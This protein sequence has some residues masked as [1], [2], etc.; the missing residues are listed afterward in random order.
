[1]FDYSGTTALNNKS[2]N[3]ISQG[4]FA[5][6]EDSRKRVKKYFENV[7]QNIIVVGQGSQIKNVI[8]RLHSDLSS[9]N[10]KNVVHVVVGSDPLNSVINGLNEY[11]QLYPTIECYNVNILLSISDTEEKER[12]LKQYEQVLKNFTSQL[13]DIKKQQFII[14]KN[15]SSLNETVVKILLTLKGSP[16][17]II[18]EAREIL[19]RE[20][21]D[22][23]KDFMKSLQEYKKT[24]D[25]SLEDA[26]QTKKDLSILT[27][28][29]SKLPRSIQ[30]SFNPVLQST[31]DDVNT[32]YNKQKEKI[33]NQQLK[34]LINVFKKTNKENAIIDLHTLSTLTMLDVPTIITLIPEFLKTQPEFGYL[35]NRL[36]YLNENI[37]LKAGQ[38]LNGLR[39]DMYKALEASN[40]ENAHVS[41]QQALEY[42]DFL[43]RGYNFIKKPDIAQR[44]IN[45]KQYLVQELQDIV[46]D[47]K[48]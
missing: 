11:V 21:K 17:I 24:A 35:D 37:L 25:K 12:L 3:S 38:F 7:L 43:V 33:I 41:L 31:I 19:I 8:Q 2:L 40:F 34:T 16:T 5:T 4:V 30:V 42:Y 47:V 36:V 15:L 29:L 22:W 1:M 10:P 39:A 18:E 20:A 28:E 14:A 46:K 6:I 44:F 48:Q 23:S 13:K 45:E 32:I 26:E 27:L 9:F